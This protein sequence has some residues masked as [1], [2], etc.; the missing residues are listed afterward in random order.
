MKR[1]TPKA[2]IIRAAVTTRVRSFLNTNATSAVP[3]TQR[4]EPANQKISAVV[5][6]GV[7]F[8][9]INTKTASKCKTIETLENFSFIG[10]SSKSGSPLEELKDASEIVSQA[11][12]P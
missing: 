8:N 5:S 2:E 6:G 12:V 1:S 7:L 9:K 4:T 11:T 3:R 10:L